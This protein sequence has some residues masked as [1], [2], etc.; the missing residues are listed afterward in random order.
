MKNEEIERLSK[1]VDALRDS[2]LR[3]CTR[4]GGVVAPYRPISSHGQFDSGN[5][6]GSYFDPVQTAVEPGGNIYSCPTCKARW[7]PV[8][9]CDTGHFL[10]CGHFM[11]M[12]AAFC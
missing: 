6:L 7:Q 11:P 10:R 12:Y 8:G 5:V 9:Y 1:S 2:V 3:H 4:C